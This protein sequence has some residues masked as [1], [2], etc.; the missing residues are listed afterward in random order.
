MKLVE[1]VF[2]R[3]SILGCGPDEFAAYA[4]VAPKKRT[5]FKYSRNLRTCSIL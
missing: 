2:T 3:M 5:Q 4:H 1:K